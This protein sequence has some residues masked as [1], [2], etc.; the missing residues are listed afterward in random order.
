MEQS[1]KMCYDALRELTT[2]DTNE[3]DQMPFAKKKAPPKKKPAPKRADPDLDKVLREIENQRSHRGGH[4]PT[5]PKLDKLLQLMLEHFEQKGD[6]TRVMVFTTYRACVDEIVAVLDGH[7]PGLR[8]T[9]FVGQGSE[10]AG[11][12]GMAQKEQIA[13]RPFHDLI[14]TQLKL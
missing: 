11:G 14:L 1:V 2:N 10:K 3:A 6:D 9:R 8:A 7:R 12:K 5:H 4:F 13:V